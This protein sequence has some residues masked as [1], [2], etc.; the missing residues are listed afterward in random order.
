MK[1]THNAFSVLMSLYYK[2]KPEYLH[3]CFASLVQQTLPASEIIVVF[4]GPLND[5]LV[6]TVERW[7]LKL[8]IKVVKLCKNLGLGNALNEGL[9]YCSHEIVIR[10]DADDICVKE[11]FQ[12]QINEMERDEQLVLVGSC[13]EEFDQKLEHSFGI[14]SVPLTLQEIKNYAKV[15]NPFNHMT[16]AFKKTAINAVGGYLDHPFMEDYN[17]W[18][19]LISNNYQMKNLSDVLVKARTGDDMINRRRGF[20]YIKSEWKLAKEKYILQ[21]QG[22]VSCILIFITRALPRL[23]PLSIIKNIYK[24]NRTK[25]N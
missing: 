4:D 16:V 7:S 1:R 24:I 5:E 22:P 2:E 21:V 13:I 6:T 19:R 25:R 12:K 15:K 17:L 11:R 8:P 14:R 3:E 23:L 10:M 20:L 18:L 9:N